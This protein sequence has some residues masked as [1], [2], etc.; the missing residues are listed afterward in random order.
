[1]PEELSELDTL[2][3]PIGGAAHLGVCCRGQGISP[4][5]LVVGVEPEAGNFTRGRRANQGTAR[6]CDHV[7]GHVDPGRLAR[8]IGNGG[9]TQEEVS[10]R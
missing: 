7:G 6:R 2:V 9:E 8:I 3:F 4:A 1:M 10:E 5:I